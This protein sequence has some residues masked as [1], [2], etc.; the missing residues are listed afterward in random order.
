MYR[1]LLRDRDFRY[2]FSGRT[3]SAC[4]DLIAMI[5]YLFAAY[6]MTGSGT[7]TGGVAIAEALP[8]M[9]L[10][11]FGGSLGGRS[12]AM[13]IMIGI[14]AIRGAVQVG[15]FA[16]YVTGALGYPLLLVIIAAIQLGGV[17]FNPMSRTILPRVVSADQ[18]G[19]ANA[20]CELSYQAITV[21]SP[22]IVGGLLGKFGLASFF[23]FDAATYLVSAYCLVR[24]R[25]LESSPQAGA[26]VPRESGPGVRARVGRALSG[27]FRELGEVARSGSDV[28]VLLILT[29]TVVFFCTWAWQIG[30]VIKS[31]GIS[32]Q[33]AEVYAAISA[34]AA[35][36]SMIFGLALPR[37]VKRPS[38]P[39]YLAGSLVWGCGI[40]I[41]SLAGRSL[42]VLFTAA[43]LV[44]TGMTV[45]TL[46]RVYILQTRLP[47]RLRGRGFA[48]S[49]TLLY[50]SNIASLALFGVLY[51][52]VGLS[53]IFLIAGLGVIIFSAGCATIGRGHHAKTLL[54]KG[55]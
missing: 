53:Q 45:S 1:A 41:V 48:S 28:L 14:D 54:I 25:G 15:T 7:E 47:D 37:W 32:R 30:L 16:L 40:L 19:A 46:C 51:R 6:K 39:Y 21:L 9:L 35:A 12:S 22:A 55:L 13:R 4:G 33:G 49:A 18:L 20:V 36:A 44:G 42:P 3:I 27:Q 5:G 50:I 38:I 26:G 8:Y 52:L 43:C 23:L 11:I 17:F 24:M 34:V 10:G 2:Y 29:F 31:A